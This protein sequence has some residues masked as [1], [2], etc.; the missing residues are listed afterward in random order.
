MTRFLFP[1]VC[2]AITAFV[3]KPAFALPGNQVSVNNPF[4]QIGSEMVAIKNDVATLQDQVAALIGRVNS[5]EE[6]VGA[7]A[8]AIVTLRKRD[9][10][11]Q[12]M[13]AQVGLDVSVVVAAID[14]LKQQNLDLQA[15]ISANSSNIGDMED[16]IFYNLGL[17]DLLNLAI[18][19]VGQNSVT[20]YDSLQQQID[21][22]SSLI[23]FI[24]ADISNIKNMLALQQNLVSGKCPDGSAV[25]EIQVDGSFV[26]VQISGGGGVLRVYS[27]TAYRNMGA[28]ETIALVLYCDGGDIA[29][30]AGHFGYQN[31]DK[32]S[33][34]AQNYTNLGMN[35]GYGYMNSTNT[36]S[37]S[38]L[39]GI[40]VNCLDT[41]P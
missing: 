11:L 9:A 12:Q 8:D 14:G 4:S 18:E 37:Y 2:A 38:V 36:N 17:I 32:M 27:K 30:G 15:Q 16:K 1:A 31:I 3:L 24:Q 39:G 20:M 10:F 5:L 21:H 29:T 41:T 6:K 13:M 23:Q 19:N 7:N 33:N 26:C 35:Y 34:Y 25:Q 22:N 28:N 40:V